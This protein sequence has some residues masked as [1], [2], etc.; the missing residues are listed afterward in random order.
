MQRLSMKTWE[1]IFR[2]TQEAGEEIEVIWLENPGNIDS[3]WCLAT[4][5]EL[6]EDGFRTE[7]EARKR[8]EYLESILLN[9]EEQS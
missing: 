1:N 5:C 7:E 4:D 3:E 9:E 6:F 8:L 2:N